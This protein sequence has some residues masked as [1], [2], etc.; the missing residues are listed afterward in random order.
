MCFV[1][2]YQLYFWL[3]IFLIIKLFRAKTV[4]LMETHEE[5]VAVYG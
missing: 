2:L 3:F 4:K 1:L 5:R